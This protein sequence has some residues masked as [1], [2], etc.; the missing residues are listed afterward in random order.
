MSELNFKCT[1]TFVSWLWNPVRAAEVFRPGS[2]TAKRLVAK[3]SV[4]ADATATPTAAAT[5]HR[6]C[7]L[8]KVAAAMVG[9]VGIM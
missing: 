2:T 3:L 8:W 4:T 1:Q 7:Q 6:G 5:R 9:A